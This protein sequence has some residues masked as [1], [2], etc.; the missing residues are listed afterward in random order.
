MNYSVTKG[1]NGRKGEPGRFRTYEE[2]LTYIYDLKRLGIKLTLDNIRS[3]LQEMENP[4][5]TY[6]SIH[7]AGTNGKGSTAVFLSHILQNADLHVGLN[8]SPHVTDFRERIHYDNTPVS[9]ENVMAIAAYLDRY[10]AKHSLTFFETVTAL[11][12]VYFARKEVDMAVVEVGMGGRLD[13]TRLVNSLVSVVTTIH[14][15]HTNVLGRTLRQIAGEKVDILR[16]GR[17]L[18][19]GKLHHAIKKQMRETARTRSAEFFALDELV[20]CE[21][22]EVTGEGTW[23]DY[24]GCSHHMERIFLTMRGR[25]QVHNAALAI[26]TCEALERYGY[27]IPEA[28]IRKGLLD[29]YIP[30]RMEVFHGP[31]EIVFD[32]AHN[33]RGITTL[34]SEIQ[35]IWKGKA[36]LPI[37]GLVKT[38][39][40]RKILAAVKKHSLEPFL[41]TPDTPRAQPVERLSEIAE[42]LHLSHRTFDTPE[43]ALF[44]ALEEAGTDRLICVCGSFFTVCDA[45][46]ALGISYSEGRNRIPEKWNGG[47]DSTTVTPHRIER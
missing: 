20:R 11:A 33:P 12:L 27:S 17:I 36:V 35:D 44:R 9:E 7:I 15:D 16:E 34:F 8:L 4:Q 39:N 1:S 24:H 3:A 30:G 41:T 5:L 29:S 37:I 10:I 26:L 47:N 18:V 32:V 22:V 42:K 28:A 25:F 43:E 19:V 21:N 40:A 14:Y 45:M 31:G 6:P 46:K 2:A 13:A 23:F 38:K